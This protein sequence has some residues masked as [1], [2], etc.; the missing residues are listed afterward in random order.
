MDHK[1]KDQCRDTEVNCVSYHPA[2]PCPH[3]QKT[4]LNHLKITSVAFFYPESRPGHPLS[5]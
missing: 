5:L 4:T 1:R 2:Y 3:H